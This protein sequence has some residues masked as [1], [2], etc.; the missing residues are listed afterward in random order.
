[1]SGSLLWGIL[2]FF[3]V[4]VLAVWLGRSTDM[5]RDSQPVDFGGAKPP[6]GGIYRR[7]YSL[8]Q[9]QMTWWFCIVIASYV[10]I[11]GSTGKI[12]G[13]LN[14]QSLILMGIGI[15]TALG[16]TA[17]EQ[18]KKGYPTLDTFNAVVKQIDTLNAAGA[19]IPPGVIAQRDTLAADLASETFLRD[20]LTDVDGVSLHR[21]QSVAWT[22]VL[23][24]AYVLSVFAQ[25]ALPEFD[26]LLLAVL[27]ISGATYL[28]FKVPEQ[29]A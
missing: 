20:I 3:V 23:G 25:H 6:G 19:P 24:V 13:V 7:P 10:Y 29:P 4:A 2:T 28:G 9:T 15:G 5:L 18:A 1:M 14:E 17:I 22:V 8:A 26:K 11:A 16:A 21:F 27:G 12:S